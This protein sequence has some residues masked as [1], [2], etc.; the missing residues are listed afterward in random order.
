LALGTLPAIAGQCEDDLAAVDKAMA[1]AKLNG[2]QRAQL[3]DMKKQAKDLCAAGNEEEGL[4]VLAE[5]KAMLN[6]E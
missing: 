1:T 5:A 3:D 4:D 2:D 6:I